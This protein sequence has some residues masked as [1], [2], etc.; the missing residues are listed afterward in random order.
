MT[1]RGLIIGASHAAA[2]RLA[3]RDHAPLWPGLEL[4]FAA[5]QGDMADLQV[6]GTHLVP[7]SEDARTRLATF[8]GQDSFDLTQFDFVA[9]CGGTAS[10]FHAIQLYNAARCAA[11]P[12]SRLHLGQTVSLISTRCFV[13]ALTGQIRNAS[14]MPLMRAI[15]AAC[16]ARLF[17]IP[18]P[19]LSHAVLRGGRQHA[20]FVRMHKNG[21]SAALAALM[22][23]ASLLAYDGLATLVPPPPQVR[24]DHFFT[25]TRFRRGATRLGSDDSLPQPPEDML[26]G[27][28]EYG[29]HILAEL[30]A[31]L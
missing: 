30:A 4:T 15:A 13:T 31:R 6:T 12:S 7:R 27:N 29:R 16:P 28:A 21:D 17:A 14:A 20:G 26:H 1:T 2:L 10:G 24:K 11:L 23:Q 18:H 25:H 8:S 9:L 3:W 22:L 19:A 5:L